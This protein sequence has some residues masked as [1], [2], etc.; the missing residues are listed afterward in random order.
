[1]SARPDSSTVSDKTS[2]PKF[3]RNAVG[4]LVL[5]CVIGGPFVKKTHYKDQPSVDST[6]WMDMSSGLGP[7]INAF[8][9]QVLDKVYQENSKV[10]Y[11]VG[12]Q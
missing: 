8:G 5:L 4:V 2:K 3:Y 7:T 11:H 9:R 10:R 12:R 1:M 6:F